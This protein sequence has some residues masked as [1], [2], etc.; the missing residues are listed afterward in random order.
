MNPLVERFLRSTQSRVEIAPGKSIVF[1]RPLA[2]DFAEMVARSK[3]GPLDLIYEFTVAWDGFVE[4]DVFPGGDSEPLPF[5]KEL[6]CWWIKDH[7]EH[8][9]KITKAIDDEI[10]AHE[11]RVGDAKKK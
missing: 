7:P 5:D 6:F 3:A 8:W 1:R 4:L 2:G 9:N 11:K 10:G